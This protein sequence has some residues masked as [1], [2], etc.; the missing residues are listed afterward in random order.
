ME[1]RLFTK[2]TN[3]INTI[4]LL[5]LLDSSLAFHAVTSVQTFLFRRKP[6]SVSQAATVD[7][8][9]ALLSGIVVIEARKIS[10]A[11]SWITGKATTGSQALKIKKQTK[12]LFLEQFYTQLAGGSAFL[13]ITL[14]RKCALL[15]CRF[16]FFMALSS[17]ASEY[18][19]PQ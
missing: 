12:S 16:D 7:K 2:K 5:A 1:I 9:L 8:V 19:F 14:T 4:K 15:I 10:L 11:K 6:V 17:F 13:K 3:Y 18:F